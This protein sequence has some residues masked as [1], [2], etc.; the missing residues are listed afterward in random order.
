MIM[1]LKLFA[2]AALASLSMG[3]AAQNATTPKAKLPAEMEIQLKY[4]ADRLG[5]RYDAAMKK[6]RENR[7]GDFVHWGLYAIPGGKGRG[8]FIRVQPNG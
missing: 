3:A 5:K 4:G 8:R 7:L 1:N 6:F 2:A